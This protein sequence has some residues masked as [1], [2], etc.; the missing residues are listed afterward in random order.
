[1]FGNQ[2]RQQAEEEKLVSKEQ[3]PKPKETQTEKERVGIGGTKV[4]R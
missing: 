4:A 2:G 3:N 1:M